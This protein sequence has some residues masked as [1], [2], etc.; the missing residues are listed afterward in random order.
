M[1]ST[2]ERLNKL[3]N[4]FNAYQE[5]EQKDKDGDGSDLVNTRR[6]DFLDAY[7]SYYSCASV[8]QVI[9]NKRISMY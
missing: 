2:E 9:S 6:G 8:S 3:L 7:R 4:A 5:S 1:G